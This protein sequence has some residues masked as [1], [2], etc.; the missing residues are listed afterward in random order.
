MTGTHM[1]DAH[2]TASRIA[3]SHVIG[4]RAFPRTHRMPC[5]RRAH[6][7]TL[8]ELMIAMLLG[9]IVVGSA[10]AIFISNRQTYRATESL[11]RVQESGRMSFELMARD[12]R[13]GAGNPCGKNLP[14][15]NVLDNPTANWWSDWGVGIVGYDGAIATPGLPFGAAPQQRVAGTDAIELKSADSASARVIVNHQPAS[16]TMFLNTVNHDFTDEDILMICDNRQAAIFQVTNASP[17]TNTNVVHNR[18]GSANPGNCTKGLGL[19]V[20]CT[21]NGTSYA[22]GPNSMVTRMRSVR[23]YIGRNPNG[24]NSLFRSTMT[25]SS[26]SIAAQPQEIVEGV[27]NM[28]LQYLLR[29]TGDYV[30]AGAIPANRWRDVVAVRVNLA[31]ASRDRAGVNGAALQRTLDHTVTL[32]NRM[33]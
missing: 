5:A 18:G 11:G 32:R 4:S 10:S 21:A 31:L 1:T 27:N 14:I 33:Q 12:I 23:W 9:M 24:G 22:Y 20:V 15:A 7:M 17:G 19:P 28:T 6:G 25:S 8:V 3:G 26:G 2:I 29:D 16:A 13:E 30:D